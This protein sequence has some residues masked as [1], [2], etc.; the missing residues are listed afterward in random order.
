MA[1]KHSSAWAYGNHLVS[2]EPNIQIC[3]SC[4]K[5]YI[6]TAKA[7]NKC[8]FCTPNVKIYEPSIINSFIKEY[9]AKPTYSHIIQVSRE[10][11]KRWRK[12]H[13]EK[14][15]EYKRNHKEKNPESVRIW[16]ER[17]R[18][19]N[20]DRLKLQ[21][22]LAY[23]LNK[24][25]PVNNRAVVIPLKGSQENKTASG[26]ILPIQETSNVKY[27][28]IVYICKEPTITVKKGDILIYPYGIPIKDKDTEYEVVNLTEVIA[29][30]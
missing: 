15:R 26:I 12:N 14:V 3:P 27:G 6:P 13:P 9:K 21:Q 2:K 25:T 4:F 28:K 5:K 8:L 22:R 23:K 24:M 16:N 7:T 29:K 11:V 1:I 17:Y 18:N 10:T 20:R 30:M 19:K